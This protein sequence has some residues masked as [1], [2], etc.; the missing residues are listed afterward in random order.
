[1]RPDRTQRNV[2]KKA[3][4]SLAARALGASLADSETLVNEPAREGHRSVH[5][6]LILIETEPE[7]V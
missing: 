2:I 1:M 7:N 5:F 6:M 3:A 4:S